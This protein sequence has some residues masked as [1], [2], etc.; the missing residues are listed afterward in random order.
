MPLLCALLLKTDYD[1]Y[2]RIHN[3]V[4]LSVFD[5]QNGHRVQSAYGRYLLLFKE[6]VTYVLP[7][8][9]SYENSIT[10]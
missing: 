9:Y 3:R 5:F 6:N 4:L 8:T 2:S 1:M 10:Y 7:T